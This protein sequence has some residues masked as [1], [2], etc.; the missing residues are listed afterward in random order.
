MT[1]TYAPPAEHIAVIKTGLISLGY[2]T[3]DT[4]DEFV[5]DAY[6]KYIMI[7]QTGFNPNMPYAVGL[8]PQEI[9]DQLTPP[10]EP[11]EEP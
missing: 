4:P 11:D 7:R 5:Q 3:E 8:L 1:T 10:A 2:A 9:Q 6:F